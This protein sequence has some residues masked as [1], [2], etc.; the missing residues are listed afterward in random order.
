M[1]KT[2]FYFL[3]FI[4]GLFF[5]LQ[6]SAQNITLES[7]WKTYD[8]IPKTVGGWKWLPDGKFYVEQTADANGK[9]CIIKV[10]AESGKTVDTLMKGNDF[11][12]KDS[13]KC[14][15]MQDFDLSPDGKKILIATNKEAIYRHSTMETNFIFFR[16]SKKLE[17]LSNKGK[18]RYAQF[19]ND[20]MKVC[21]I[22]NNNLFYADLLAEEITEVQMTKDGE[23]NKI[24]YGATDWVYEEE[25][26][27]NR[28]F[29]W[30][31][32]NKKILY[33]RFDESNVKEYSLDYFETKNYPR[34]EKYK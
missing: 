17:A 23:K 20:G 6:L 7:V 31:P 2:Q 30:S 22:I 15:L 27:I 10:E 3:V 19:S 4:S 18:Q 13:I 21:Y 29:Y 14:I 9:Q 24:I 16:E 11:L 34:N 33:Y 1:R 5:H 25:F 32:D 26:G 8:Y 28:A 12:P